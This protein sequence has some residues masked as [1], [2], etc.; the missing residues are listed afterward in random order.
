MITPLASRALA[1]V[2][3]SPSSWTDALAICSSAAASKTR[4]NCVSTLA[5]RSASAAAISARSP[6]LPSS[7][8]SRSSL[9]RNSP[10]SG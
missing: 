3:C 9:A 5:R 2:T 6:A 8:V 4:R 1:T 10:R 7:N